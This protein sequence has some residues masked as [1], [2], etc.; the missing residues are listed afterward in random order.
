MKKKLSKNYGDNYVEYLVAWGRSNEKGPS[1]SRGNSTSKSKSNKMLNLFTSQ[2]L[3]L[4]F[5][6]DLPLLLAKH[7]CPLMLSQSLLH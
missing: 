5:D 6:L 1:S 7:P 2:L 4:V 3:N